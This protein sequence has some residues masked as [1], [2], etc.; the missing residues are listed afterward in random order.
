MRWYNKPMKPPNEPCY[1][2]QKRLL[3]NSLKE[4]LCHQYLNCDLVDV[5]ANYHARKELE[6]RIK[7]NYR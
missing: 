3:K 4:T 1:K 2:K 5:C 6:I 7:D